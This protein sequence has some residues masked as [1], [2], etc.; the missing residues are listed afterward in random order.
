MAVHRAV[1]GDV[2]AQASTMTTASTRRK[3]RVV[4]NKTGIGREE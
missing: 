3:R 1:E 2:V 4:E